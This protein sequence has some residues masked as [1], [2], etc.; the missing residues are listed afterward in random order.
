ELAVTKS[1]TLT[2]KYNQIP[3]EDVY[4]TVTFDT[5]GAEAIAAVDILEGNKLTAPTA[6][7]KDNFSFEGWTLD[8]ELFDF[9]TPVTAD[10]ELKAKFNFIGIPDSPTYVGRK[11][12]GDFDQLLNNFTSTSLVSEIA[13]NA[14]IDSE[15]PYT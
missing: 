14:Y 5:V 9:D 1:F 6:P 8:G 4:Y 12:N 2:A 15:Q 3:A 10:F 11:Y 7:T 13:E